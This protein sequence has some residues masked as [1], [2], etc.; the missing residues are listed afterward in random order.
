M[1]GVTAEGVARVAEFT[2][3]AG[4][5]IK[6]A[7]KVAVG[8][9][10]TYT[11]KLGMDKVQE[12][13]SKASYASDSDSARH[14]PYGTVPSTSPITGIGPSIL[15]P[16]A[17]ET[18]RSTNNHGSQS[19]HSFHSA[20]ATKTQTWAPNI[21]VTG[22]GVRIEF[23]GSAWPLALAAV[24]I[25]AVGS[26]LVSLTAQTKQARCPRCLYFG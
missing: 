18:I 12:A 5:V 13:Y 11:G 10:V 26:W 20:T 7:A 19:A 21:K 1:A 24:G 25:Y 9:G 22:Q 8:I 14:D 3:V 15:T 2:K 4:P 23:P 17:A 6:D 16:D